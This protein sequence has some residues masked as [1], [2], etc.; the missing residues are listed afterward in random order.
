M[1]PDN[2]TYDVNFEIVGM[3]QSNRHYTFEEIPGQ[4]TKI[5]FDDSYRVLSAGMK[6]L[7]VLGLFKGMYRKGSERILKTYIS[8]A[9]DQLAEKKR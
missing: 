4:G 5:R 7:D 2:H 6:I 1:H 8:E 3:L 9:E